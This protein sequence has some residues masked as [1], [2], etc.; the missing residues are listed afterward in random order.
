MKDL[1]LSSSGDVL[2][3]SDLQLV[4]GEDELAQSV[5]LILSIRLGEF[6]L[7]DELGLSHENMLAKNFNEEYLSQD[8]VWAI[9]DQEPRVASVN[10]VEIIK[11]NRDLSVRVR[12]IA[13]D[14]REIEV[15]ANA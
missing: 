14:G 11:N 3:E 10:E 6:F 4:D 7:E 12:M 1:V 9:T 13:A 8:I 5:L 15:M 2:F